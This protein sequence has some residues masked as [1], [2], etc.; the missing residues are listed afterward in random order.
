M[1]G[2]NILFANI[3]FS[4]MSHSPLIFAFGKVR[5]YTKVEKAMLSPPLEVLCRLHSFAINYG[6]KKHLL[7]RI[8]KKWFFLA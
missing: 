4:F 1:N 5:Q 3:I 8:C 2:S 7:Q 6:K